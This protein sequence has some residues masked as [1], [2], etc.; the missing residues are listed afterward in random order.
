MGSLARLLRSRWAGT[1]LVLVGLLPRGVAPTNPLREKVRRVN[2]GLRSLVA[3]EGSER[4]VY[5]DA[6]ALMPL[7]PDGSLDRAWTV[8]YVHLTSEM[9]DRY[10][11]AL[12]TTLRSFIPPLAAT[13]GAARIARW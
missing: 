3:R 1:A 8:D 13:A 7:L 12:L 10:G 6:P 5:L 4:L 11:K 9:Y 2:L